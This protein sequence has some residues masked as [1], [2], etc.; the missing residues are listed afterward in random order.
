MTNRKPDAEEIAALEAFAAA[1]GRKWK[2]ILSDTYWY[3]ARLWT[4]QRGDD[5]RIGSILH[6]IRNDFG[7]SWLQSFKLP[8]KG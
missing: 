3:N 2:S 8:S 5:Q 7:P 6:G 1:H 4:G